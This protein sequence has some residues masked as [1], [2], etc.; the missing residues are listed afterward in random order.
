MRCLAAMKFLL[1]RIDK[2]LILFLIWSIDSKLRTDFVI[3]YMY[4]SETEMSVKS[5]IESC[6]RRRFRFLKKNSQFDLRSLM[7]PDM[8]ESVEELMS[9]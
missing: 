1:S 9:C 2:S 7:R 6:G 8:V 3:M 4:S 5:E